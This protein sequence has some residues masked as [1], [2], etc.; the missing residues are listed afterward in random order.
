MLEYFQKGQAE[1]VPLEEVDS[2]HWEVYYLPMHACYKEE[3]TTSKLRIVLDASAKTLPGTSLNDHLLVGSTVHP[4]LVDALLRFRT[5][6]IPLTTDV[7]RMY[8]AVKLAD[9]QKDLHQFVWRE[10][11]KQSFQHYRM[12]RLTFGVFASSFAANRSLRKNSEEHRETHP[13]ASRKALL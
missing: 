3:S 5:L 2:P 1:Q 4:L 9:D 11:P 13:Q 6:C 10:D 8:R 7:S 12:T